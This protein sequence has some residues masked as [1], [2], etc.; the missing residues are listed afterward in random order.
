[1][2]KVWDCQ[3]HGAA[4]TGIG[5][6]FFENHSYFTFTQS[7]SVLLARRYLS[8]SML[9]MARTRL[10]IDGRGRPHLPPPNSTT[11]E[12]TE[13]TQSA[14]QSDIPDRGLTREGNLRRQT[15]NHWETEEK[16]QR[17]K[18]AGGKGGEGKEVQKD[19]AVRERGN[20]E[21]EECQMES[22]DATKVD[23]ARHEGRRRKNDSKQDDGT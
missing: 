11:H 7:T 14:G 1:M 17:G 8:S 22:G 9:I 5:H 23:R 16:G 3:R 20:E 21:K 13:K 19:K 18:E 10:G 15:E 2:S 12:T 6:V 4:E